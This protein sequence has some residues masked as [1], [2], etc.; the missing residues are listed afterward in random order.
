MI[1]KLTTIGI[2]EII[3]LAI[4]FFTFS[5]IAVYAQSN[6]LLRLA[7]LPIPPPKILSIIGDAQHRSVI[8]LGQSDVKDAIINI[9][10]ITNPS[11]VVTKTNPDGSFVTVL[12]AS[13][14]QPGLTQFVAT[15]IIN[16]DYVTDPGNRVSFI[17]NTD[18]SVTKN[19]GSDD[20][21]YIGA[22]DVITEQLFDTLDK[23]AETNIV[24]IPASGVPNVDL[25]S[26]L[27]LF[28][29]VVFFIVLFVQFFYLLLRRAL[30]KE[31]EHTSFF[32][33]GHGIY[34]HPIPHTR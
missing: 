22:S 4:I 19:P 28:L 11:I 23:N 26:H 2:S 33:L 3:F 25:K 34:S 20:S 7:I 16:G 8:I 1:K 13:E 31:Q 32:K 5:G 10:N 9:Y 29:Q 6:T 30:R 24:T 18:Y 12:N 17:V 15:A 27:A 14:I 21:V